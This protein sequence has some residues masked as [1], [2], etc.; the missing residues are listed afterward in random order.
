L[1]RP[2]LP[3]WNERFYLSN[4]KQFERVDPDFKM[5][6]ERYYKVRRPTTK[7]AT[8]IIGNIENEFRLPTYS[9]AFKPS[10]IIGELE[11]KSNF[12]KYSKDNEFYPRAF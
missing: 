4:Y 6:N 12:T 7:K 10:S 8:N 11:W 2:R 3:V 5:G 9:K 1:K